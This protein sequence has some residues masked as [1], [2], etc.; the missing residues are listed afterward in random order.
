MGSHSDPGGYPCHDNAVVI[1]RHYQSRK[2]ARPVF[3]KTDGASVSRY[4]EWRTAWIIYCLQQMRPWTN[5][6][7]FDGP[8][9]CRY[10]ERTAERHAPH[11]P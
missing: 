10:L 2:S 1:L 3:N 7:G 6:K 9:G 4:W 5:D 11:A 8:A